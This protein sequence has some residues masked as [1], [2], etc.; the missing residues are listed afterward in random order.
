MAFE[1]EQATL[2][3]LATVVTGD[4]EAARD[5]VS[6]AFA[7]LVATDGVRDPAA[8]L[9]VAVT[10]RSTSWVRRQIVARSDLQ[11]YGTPAEHTDTPDGH[12]ERTVTDRVAVRD[13]LARLDHDQRAAVFLRFYLDRPEA[14]IAEALGCRPGTVKSRL[15]RAMSRLREE[16]T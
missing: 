11:R 9:R 1:R 5:L 3:R 12:L 6:E 8:W 10:R 13:A 2:L 4:P 16:L 7:D 15:S 14:E